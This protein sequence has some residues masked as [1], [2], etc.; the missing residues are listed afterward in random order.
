MSYTQLWC[1]FFLLQP[2]V[3][4]HLSYSGQVYLLLISLQTIMYKKSILA[5]YQLII[6]PDQL[7]WVSQVCHYICIGQKKKV[8]SNFLVA[9][10]L[11]LS[12]SAILQMLQHVI[13]SLREVWL[14][15]FLAKVTVWVFVQYNSKHF[16]YDCVI[17][18]WVL[19]PGAQNTGER[20]GSSVPP[21]V[22]QW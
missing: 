20:Q 18:L 16:D 15:F 3:F 6:S 9:L 1:F 17:L 11:L 21:G 14:Y 7:L 8:L 10:C 5:Y 19:L 22:D 12:S 2:S 13:N 4:F